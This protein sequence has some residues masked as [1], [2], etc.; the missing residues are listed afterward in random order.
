MSNRGGDLEADFYLDSTNDYANR[1]SSAPPDQHLQSQQ[2]SMARNP[3]PLSQQ[4]AGD[5]SS[6]SA[7]DQGHYLQQ[8]QQQAQQHWDTSSTSL[9]HVWSST[10][11]QMVPAT[12]AD[13][14]KVFEQESGK[15]SSRHVLHGSTMARN[16]EA[17]QF[18]LVGSSTSD[19]YLNT[20]SKTDNRSTPDH[21][22]R[23]W[24][25]PSFMSSSNEGGI[26]PVQGV[27]LSFL[28]LT[29]FDNQKQH[30]L[31]SQYIHLLIG[32]HWTTTYQSGT[33]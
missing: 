24:G 32:I 23:L 9:R 15:I 6:S 16:T 22:G 7:I 5:A 4:F 28:M 20:L 17:Q 1:S 14:N 13:G 25:S 21:F 27:S 12:A 3:F 18:Y 11:N 30:F 19:P 26:D 33:A 29:P 10:P 31:G 2:G 8:Q